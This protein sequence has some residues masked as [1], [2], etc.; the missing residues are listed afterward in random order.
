MVWGFLNTSLNY[1]SGNTQINFTLYPMM[2]NSLQN[3][4]MQVAGGG[5]INIPVPEQSFNILNSS[6]S[7]ITNGLWVGVSVDYSNYNAG[8]FTFMINPSGTFYVPLINTTGVTS[9]NI[10]SQSYAP[11]EITSLTTPSL[12]SSNNNITVNQFTPGQ[13][14][15]NQILANVQMQ[16][17]KS[18][19]TCDVP[20]PSDSCILLS[21]AQNPNGNPLPAIIGGGK[22]SFQM[23]L[24]NSGIIVDYVDVNMIA[25]GPPSVMFD[26]SATTSTS[27]G[28]SSAMRFGSL[29]PKIYDYAM[30]S[31]PYS[32]S[33]L[34]DSSPVNISV[35]LFYLDNVSGVMDWNK[36]IWDTTLNGTNVSSLSGN[37]SHFVGDA[38]AWQTLM[39]GTTCVTNQS[40]FNITNPCYI[41]TTNDRVWLRIPHF[42]GINP[43]IT[44]TAVIASSSGGSSGSS[45]GGGGVATISFW[46]NTV[47]VNDSQFTDGFSKE[48]SARERAEITVGTEQHY[49]GIV[50]LTTSS[51][52]INVSSSSQQ[53]MLN[54]GESQKFDVN[55]DS[56]YDILV[57]LNSINN[58]IAN[59]TILS[60][61]D[62]INQNNNPVT[63]NNVSGTEANNNENPNA[64]WLM[65]NNW[66]IVG[67][68]VFLIIIIILVFVL[69]KRKIKTK[70]FFDKK[71]IP[72]KY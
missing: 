31:I 59:M 9:I 63:Q 70:K 1:N 21:S 37:Y 20:N 15:N 8:Q 51:V 56:Y 49:V 3:I 64:I 28:F 7:L 38:S 18:N 24:L 33:Q 17:L 44:G 22:V 43:S 4:S 71:T 16:L 11:E 46:T 27:G 39:L 60:I 10:Y 2:G 69:R 23:G 62:L 26:S 12:I 55:N 61:H 41:D 68:I 52:T 72:K 35:P 29:G 6:G 25:S 57:T 54:I 53:A 67:I 19:S 32:T 47:T 48:Y 58:S 40:N 5:N 66:L 36:P 30:I 34:V 50:S 45:G 14:I 13:G 42:S 65:N